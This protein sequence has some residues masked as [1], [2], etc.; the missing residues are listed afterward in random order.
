[1]AAPLMLSYLPRGS[2]IHKL[3]GTT[4]L[5]FFM[6]VSISAMVTYDTR[7]LAVLLAGTLVLF[8]CS[9]LHLRDV[10]W[11]LWLAFV[12]LVLNNLFVY[13]FSPEYGVDLYESRTVLF[14]LVGRYTITTQQLFYHLNLILKVATVIPLA[15]VFILCTDPS[16]FA[17]S[18]SS[19]G[20]SYR[21]GYSVAL[22]LR[23]IPDIQRDY[24]EISQ[25]QQAR[26][27]DIS[28]KD[29][30]WDRLKGSV[31]ILMPLILSSLSRIDTISNAMELRGF[32]KNRKRTWY[33]LRP[34]KRNDWIALGVSIAILAV[35]LF[36]AWMDG[37]RFW[38][39]FLG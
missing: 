9:R 7:L 24:R 30:F 18:L 28:G 3:T 12:F 32:G 17:A 5:C 27:V 31:N 20:I 16:E 8:K 13:I 38:N 4:K 26:G 2:F 37:S 22:A 34:F 29:K 25:A 19:V 33:V 21:I 1:M 39:P 35:T 23:Y 10:K 15:L 14:T 36:V 6:L 11:V